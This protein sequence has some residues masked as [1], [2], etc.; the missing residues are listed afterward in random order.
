MLNLGRAR[1][2]EYLELALI[3][4]REGN[5]GTGNSLTKKEVWKRVG[6]CFWCLES[7]PVEELKRSLR[8]LNGRF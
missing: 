1:H 8:S 3:V 6:I 5:C 2:L 7:R 4:V